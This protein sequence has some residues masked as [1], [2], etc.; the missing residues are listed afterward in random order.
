MRLTINVL[1]LVCLV[2]T[3]ACFDEDPIIQ[4]SSSST[5]GVDTTTEPPPTAT[6]GGGSSSASGTGDSTGPSDPS[7]T[8]SPPG[9]TEGMTT[10]EPATG[11]ETGSTSTEGTTGTSGTGTGDTG[12]GTTGDACMPITNDAS[13]IA[14]DCVSDLDCPAGYTCQPFQGFVMQMQCQIL[15]TDVCEC[16]PGLLCNPVMDKSGSSWSQCE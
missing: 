16:P 5:S 1:G 7:E 10:G 13:G 2:A 8:D 3:A 4:N 12:T 15:C 14:V 11:T 9:E 6:Q